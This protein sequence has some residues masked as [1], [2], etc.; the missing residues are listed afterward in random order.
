MWGNLPELGA[1]VKFNN[2]QATISL[3]AVPRKVSGQTAER[4]VCVAFDESINQGHNHLRV[5]SLSMTPTPK[6]AS[7]RVERSQITSNLAPRSFVDP[8]QR[9]VSWVA[10]TRYLLQDHNFLQTP[11]KH[12]EDYEENHPM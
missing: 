12:L 3:V 11:T 4:N 8:L 6:Q 7:G 2:G 9:R 5:L 10:H 1:I